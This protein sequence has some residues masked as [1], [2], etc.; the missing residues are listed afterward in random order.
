M[1]PTFACST[2]P[3][4]FSGDLRVAMRDSHGL[5][6]VQRQQQ[7]R[8][9][10]AEQIDDTVMQAAEARAGIDREIG[11][12]Q[13]SQQYGEQIAPNSAGGVG[14]AVGVTSRMP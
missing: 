7:L 11:N 14:E 6:F 8:A 3:I 1:S 4:G 5:R 2:T 10:I 9:A 13:P 12:F